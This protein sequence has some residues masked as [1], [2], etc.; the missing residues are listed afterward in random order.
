MDAPSQRV[1][2]RL[3]LS[4]QGQAAPAPGQRALSLEAMGRP[5]PVAAEA[6]LPRKR[7]SM[8]VEPDELDDPE[9]EERLAKRHQTRSAASRRALTADT[10]LVHRDE[11]APE[12]GGDGGGDGGG[13]G[14]AGLADRVESLGGQLLKLPRK[15]GGAELRMVLDLR[16]AG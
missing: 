13:L 5:A 15:G 2:V 6:F 9:S 1:V 14:L 3:T 7:T 10:V 12:G 11:T 16:E 8:P 4:G